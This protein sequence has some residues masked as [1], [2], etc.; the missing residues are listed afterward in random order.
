MPAAS[1]EVEGSYGSDPEDPAVA[2]VF[3]APLEGRGWLIAGTALVATGGTLA[4]TAAVR[5]ARPRQDS[6]LRPAA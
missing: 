4:V 1:P 3:I 6:N 5:P 2:G